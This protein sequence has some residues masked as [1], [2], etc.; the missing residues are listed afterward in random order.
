MS[1]FTVH[2]FSAQDGTRIHYRRYGDRE[3][4]GTPVLCLAG[5][6]RNSRDFNKLAIR[7][8]QD[9]LVLCPDYRGR[10]QSDRADYRTYTPVNYVSDAMHL[11]TVEDIH[12]V[13]VIGTSLG[14]LMAMALA[15]AIPAALAGVVI[16]DVGPDISADGQTRI[17]NYVGVDQRHA[18]LELAAAAMRDTYGRAF[19]DWS[20]EDWLTNAEG[21][22]VRDET[23]GNWKLDYDLAL[24]DALAEQARSGGIPDLWALFRGLAHMPA[25]LVHGALSDVLKPATV[26]RMQQA[27]S[28]LELVTLDNR[29]HA[30]SMTEPACLPRILQ[31]LEHCDAN[32]DH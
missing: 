6:T 18:T 4:T 1:I 23:A 19:P 17:L 30:P 8:G 2:D 28:G 5:L 10:G 7:L 32:N 27:M 13:I 3:R 24:R 25:L 9:R 20:E 11:L 12:R 14:G 15:V 22:Y 26:A 21:T 29:G 31:F 16:N